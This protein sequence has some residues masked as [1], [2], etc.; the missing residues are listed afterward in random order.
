MASLA[1]VTSGPELI[2]GSIPIFL[3]RNGKNKPNVVA[4]IIAENIAIVKASAILNPELF[5]TSGLVSI[6]GKNAH[7]KPPIIPQLIATIAAT[8]TSRANT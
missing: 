2:A 7:I 3:K 4:T 6:A 5:A 8:L 1:V